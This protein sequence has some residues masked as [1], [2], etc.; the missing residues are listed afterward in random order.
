MTGSP[1]KVEPRVGGKFTAWDGYIT[2]K[3]TRAETLY[4]YRPG[5]ADI[6]ISR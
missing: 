6:G 3:D 2:G 5:V 4:P 1:A